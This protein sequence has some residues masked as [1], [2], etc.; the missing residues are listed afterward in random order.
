MA[1]QKPGV[2]IPLYEEDELPVPQRP[3]IPGT[4]YVDTWWNRLVHLWE[5]SHDII[6]KT[7]PNVLVMDDG[8]YT[9]YLDE[10]NDRNFTFFSGEIIVIPRCGHSIVHFF[11]KSYNG[12][13]PSFS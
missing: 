2:K 3:L 7:P 8:S 12:A 9:V 1:Y 11:V 5:T 13:N 4:N 6:E 10:C